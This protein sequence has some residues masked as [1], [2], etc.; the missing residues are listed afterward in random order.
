MM[1]SL[2]NLLLRILKKNCKRTKD[3][4][5][6][7]NSKNS[8][9]QLSIMVEV[10]EDKVALQNKAEELTKKIVEAIYETKNVKGF[11]DS[12]DNSI[13]VLIERDNF[14]KLLTR[15]HKSEGKKNLSKL[16][17][18]ESGIT[19]RISQSQ[20]FTYEILKKLKINV[21]EFFSLSTKDEIEEYNIKSNENQ[22]SNEN[23]AVSQDFLLELNDKIDFITD[24]VNVNKRSACSA[25]FNELYR[26]VMIL[27]EQ[28]E[29][30]KLSLSDF[31]CPTDFMLFIVDEVRKLG[32][33]GNNLL[34][35]CKRIASEKMFLEKHTVLLIYSDLALLLFIK[36]L[37][38]FVS[39]YKAMHKNKLKPALIIEDDESNYFREIDNEKRQSFFIDSQIKI[40]YNEALQ[41]IDASRL[42][43]K[44]PYQGV[45]DLFIK[46]MNDYM[47]K[48]AEIFF[49]PQAM[50]VE[51]VESDFVKLYNFS[52]WKAKNPQQ[53]Y[54][55]LF[56]TKSFYQNTKDLRKIVEGDDPDEEDNGNV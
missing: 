41:M 25:R 35:A 37:L 33:K 53:K 11:Y 32:F 15:L 49:N 39:A 4:N 34:E 21:D 5:C 54:M 1:K 46:Y 31:E 12:L 38:L 29:S 16:R 28:L 30:I 36:K 47:K 13:K 45:T 50:A 52:A 48:A 27:N 40:L 56:I 23:D 3:T 18:S 55:R 51:K 8:V 26:Y 10:N 17:D 43:Q 22:H 20:L 9:I 14:Q 42:K 44:Q 24:C 19:I 7:S 2:M 6:F